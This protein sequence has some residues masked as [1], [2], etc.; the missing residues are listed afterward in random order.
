MPSHPAEMLVVGVPEWDGVLDTALAMRPAM[1]CGNA[2]V[3]V[4]SPHV[5]T[6]LFPRGIPPKSPNQ[7]ARG[8]EPMHVSQSPQLKSGPDTSLTHPGKLLP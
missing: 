1:A 5:P 6:R 8:F 7:H 2:A 4:L 3:G